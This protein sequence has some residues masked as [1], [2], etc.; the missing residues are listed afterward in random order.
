LHKQVEKLAFIVDR[1]PKPELP[2]T[3]HYG[4]LEMPSCRWPWASTAKFLS[5][6]RPELQDPPPHCFVRKIQAALSEQVF[7]VAIA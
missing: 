6:Q 4:H 3:N 1:A 5:E 7:D 2:A